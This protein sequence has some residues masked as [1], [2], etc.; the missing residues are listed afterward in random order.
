MSPTDTSTTA[1]TEAVHRGPG[2]PRSPEADHAILEATIQLLAEHGYAGLS[3]EGVAAKAGVGK[4]TVYRRWPSKV[5][6]VLDAISQLAE[7]IAPPDTD[8]TRDALVK[9]M[10]G[11]IRLMTR[12]AAGKVLC[13]LSEELQHNKELAETVRSRY[14]ARRRQIV[15]DIVDRGVA[16]GELRSDADREL[17]ADMLA[18]PVVYRLML[19][20]A[21]ITT[22]MADRIVDTLLQGVGL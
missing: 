20:G 9:L 6:L 11:M 15:F 18:G 21:H 19:S 14:I 10:S 4:T 12:S 8:S 2:R 3:I 13:G 22:D 7:Q 5:P 17:I 1:P 16:R